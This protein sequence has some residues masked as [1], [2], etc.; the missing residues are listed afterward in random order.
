ML[1]A[2]VLKSGAC[3]DSRLVVSDER[4][5]FGVMLRGYASS[6]TWVLRH[7]HMMLAVTLAT[8]ALTVYLYVLVKRDFSPAG[9]RPAVRKHPGG[10]GISRFRRCGRNSPKW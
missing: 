8:M 4:A 9:Y 7:P 2:R 5:G 10:A 6:L 1:C 3:R